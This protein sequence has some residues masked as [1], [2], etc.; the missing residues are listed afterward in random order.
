MTKEELAALGV[1]DEAAAKVLKALGDGYIEK[2][3]FAESENSVKSLTEQLAARDTQL[4]ELGKTAGL[5]AEL[6]KQIEALQSENAE[7]LKA[8]NAEIARLKLDNAI[9]AALTASGAR[10]NK[11][12][13]SLIDAGKLKLSED[14]TLEG[15]KEQ[16]DAVRRSDSY[17]FEDKST[18]TPTLKGFTPSPSAD[19]LPAA[20]ISKMKYSELS[21]YMEANP[22]AKLT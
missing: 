10:N 13:R 2:N 17:L 7:Q 21:A 22:N 8:H 19:G 5:N 20:D 14:G 9:E 3:R 18:K 6:K 1:P 11:A 15:L 16:L 12:V 4:D